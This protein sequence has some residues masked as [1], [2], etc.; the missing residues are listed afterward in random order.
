[1]G[2]SYQHNNVDTLS[3][4]VLFGTGQLSLLEIPITGVPT[5]RNP[6]T[7][8][9]NP[10]RPSMFTKRWP[11]R[12]SSGAGRSPHRT[13]RNSESL[14][15]PIRI[16]WFRRSTRTGG[17]PMPN[18]PKVPGSES[19]PQ[20]CRSAAF[21]FEPRLRLPQ[22]GYQILRY[23]PAAADGSAD[24]RA[25]Q[26]EYRESRPIRAAREFLLFRNDPAGCAEVLIPLSRS[27][28]IT[29]SAARRTMLP[30]YPFCPMTV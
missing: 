9:R 4:A 13:W 11:S 21:G 6:S 15:E 3:A 2:F 14:P 20:V 5:V 29:R 25:Y 17:D 12:E 10:S 24:L 7:G 19:S 30:L 22:P 1:M 28:R 27:M 18:K 8:T 23:G 26:P 16:R